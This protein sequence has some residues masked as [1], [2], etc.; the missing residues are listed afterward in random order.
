MKMRAVK[1]KVAMIIIMMI[2]YTSIKQPY[3]NQLKTA[4]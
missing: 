3:A 2:V 1:F 4:L